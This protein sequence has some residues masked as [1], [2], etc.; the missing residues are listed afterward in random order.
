MQTQTIGNAALAASLVVSA[1]PAK[2]CGIYGVNNGASQQYIQIHE[3]PALPA[4]GATPRL[5][6]PVGAGQFYS[7]EFE[8]GMDLDAVTVCNSS[9]L[10]TKTIGANNCAFTA[11]VAL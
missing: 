4:D 8:A 10:A 9:T 6:I 5:S 3:A 2:L 11:L 1:R 7:I